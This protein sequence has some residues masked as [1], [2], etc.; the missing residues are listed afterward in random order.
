[1]ST[2]IDRCRRGFKY[3]KDSHRMVLESLETV[4]EGA[5]ASESYQNAVN[6]MGH[7]VAARRMWLHRLNP[8]IKRP[9]NLFSFWTR[10][11]ATPPDPDAVAV[12]A[13]RPGDH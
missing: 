6:I 13:D 4:A 7:V 3:E 11:P 1:M 5:R 10:E 9:A 2:L 12:A 8:T